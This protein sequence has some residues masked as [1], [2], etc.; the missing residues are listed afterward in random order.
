MFATLTALYGLGTALFLILRLLPGEEL[1]LVGLFNTT[2]PALLLPA[3]ALL[4]A[5]LL[6]RRWWLAFALVPAILAFTFDNGAL[7]LPQ[8]EPPATAPRVSLL[9]YNLHAE[10]MALSPMVDL[11]R[12]ADADIVALQELSP[13]AAEVFGE[14]LAGVYPHQALH[15]SSGNPVFGQGVL[16]KY[17][18][19]DSAYWHVAMWHQ[20][21]V[22][23]I[24]GMPVALY[25]VHPNIP[26]GHVS[27]GLA[28][29]ANKRGRDIADILQRAR[30]EK[31][32]VILAGDFNM[33]D[34]SAHYRLVA[35]EYRDAFREAGWGLGFSIPDLS[36]PNAMSP[37]FPITRLPIPLLSRI[38]YVFFD[39]TFAADEARVWPTSGGSDHRPVFARLAVLDPR[40]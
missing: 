35:A 26:F 30:Q 31:I 20:R 25:N 12:A 6:A 5:W 3:F 18:L 36:S 14:Q 40:R 11:I 4:V 15:P 28:F 29:N 22:V 16:S 2:L 19:H 23:E 9:T 17:P 10:R 33:S 24:D 13:E 32:P 39:D 34:S 7:F 1:P 27:G 8:P 38:D 37:A 21:V